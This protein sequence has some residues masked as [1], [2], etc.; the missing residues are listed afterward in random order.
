MR[1][2]SVHILQHKID[3]TCLPTGQTILL[4]GVCSEGGRAGEAHGGGE[5]GGGGG[6]DE[7]GQDEGGPRKGEIEEGDGGKCSLIQY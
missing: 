6:E 3:C 7:G 1:V 2:S 5:A 4:Q